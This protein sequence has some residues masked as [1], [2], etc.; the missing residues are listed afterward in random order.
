[1]FFTLGLVPNFIRYAFQP[2]SCTRLTGW[3]PPKCG[4][5]RVDE[6]HHFLFILQKNTHL[7][8]IITCACTLH[9]GVP[10]GWRDTRERKSRQNLITIVHVYSSGD[11][12]WNWGCGVF[13][14]IGPSSKSCKWLNVSAHMHLYDQLYLYPCPPQAQKRQFPLQLPL[15]NIGCCQWY[16]HSCK[17]P[18]IQCSS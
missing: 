18:A 4:V 6:T 16:C 8:K 17:E 9:Q 3:L 11:I 14:F 10:R 2:G 15:K 7:V 13:S 1:M 5:D 12:M